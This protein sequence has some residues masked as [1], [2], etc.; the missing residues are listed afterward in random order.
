MEQAGHRDDWIPYLE[1]GILQS[2]LLA[3]LQAEAELRLHLGYLYQLIGKLAEADTQ[4]RFSAKCFE[5]LDELHG[6]ARA[7]NRLAYIARLQRKYDEANKFIEIVL[8]LLDEEDPERANSHFVLGIIAFDTRDWQNALH[9][10]Q[11]SLHVWQKQ[12]DKRQI[13]WGL[14]NLGPTLHEMG[15]YEQAVECYS[16]AIKLLEEMH[17]LAQQAVTQMNLGVVYLTLDQPQQ[18]LGLFLCADPILRKVCDDLHRAMNY[19]NMGIAHRM[20]KEWNQAEAS[21]LSSVERW[22]QIGNTEA[23][24]NVIDELGLVYLE[25]GL[26]EKAMATFQDA[27]ERLAPIENEPGYQHRYETIKKHLEKAISVYG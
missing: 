3:D 15:R 24:A 21:L 6:R 23:I 27:L 4:S 14:R 2:N 19:C 13:A 17:D 12:G 5:S 22:E 16:N 9:H 26:L 18:A 10:F 11:C 20:L 7:L 25:Q 8:G 1:Q